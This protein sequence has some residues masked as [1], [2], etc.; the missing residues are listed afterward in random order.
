MPSFTIKVV[1]KQ[2]VLQKLENMQGK[3]A[4]LVMQRTMAD[5]AKK[6]PSIIAKVLSTR[7]AMPASKLNPNSKA[8]Q[9]HKSGSRGSVSMGG[10]LASIEFEYR[11]R[12]LAIGGGATASE[13]SWP[14]QPRSLN[15]KNRVTFK[16]Q[17]LRGGGRKPVGHWSKPGSEGGKYGSKSPY[18]A[19][20]GPNT[21][22][23]RI[24]HGT[25]GAD[26]GP[27]IPALVHASESQAIYMPLLEQALYET[28]SRHLPAIV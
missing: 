19:L 1:N 2:E 3:N 17:I 11:G 20:P 9:S 4:Q 6:G 5:M 24:G 28:V 22:M 18:M 25:G 23:Q 26:K 8:N 27:S 12:M 10:T 16:T 21:P 13:G 15:Y 7:Y 14:L